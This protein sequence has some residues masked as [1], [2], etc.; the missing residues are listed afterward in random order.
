MVE[1]V[2]LIPRYQGFVLIFFDYFEAF[3]LVIER[4]ALEATIVAEGPFCYE[5][6]RWLGAGIWLFYLTALE[7]DPAARPVRVELL[8][9]LE[10]SYL[11][12]MDSNDFSDCMHLRKLFNIFAEYC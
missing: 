7:G 5:W 4:R 3:I 6:P 11:G 2:L 8:L 1:G 12:S 9:A 10:V